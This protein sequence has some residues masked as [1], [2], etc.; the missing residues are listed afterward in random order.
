MHLMCGAL[1]P[2]QTPKVRRRFPFFADESVDDSEAGSPSSSKLEET[3]LVHAHLRDLRH[4][5]PN[6]CASDRWPN[7]ALSRL[8]AKRK[9]P[10][11]WVRH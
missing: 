3:G 10:H 6:S 5:Q 7:Q 2:L 11:L 9:A 8:S 4:G 1:R